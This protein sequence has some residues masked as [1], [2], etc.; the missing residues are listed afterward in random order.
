MAKNKDKLESAPYIG[1]EMLPWLRYRV[2][3]HHFNVI[4]MR[5]RTDGGL[6]RWLFHMASRTG[7]DKRC[8]GVIVDR[9]REWQ[10]L[11]LPFA[12]LETNDDDGHD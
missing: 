8:T 10:T 11:E 6:V 12:N 1:M 3:L 7:T 4:R 5:V 2:R 9:S